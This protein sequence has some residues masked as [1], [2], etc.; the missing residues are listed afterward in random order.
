MNKRERTKML[1]HLL[2]VRESVAYLQERVR[3]SNGITLD[4]V[5]KNLQYAL[6]KEEEVCKTIGSTDLTSLY[7]NLPQEE[8]I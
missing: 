1:N 7:K 3:L 6:K 5:K 4:V 2:D 8:V